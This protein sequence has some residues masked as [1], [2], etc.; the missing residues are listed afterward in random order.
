MRQNIEEVAAKIAFLFLIR[1][2]MPLAPL[3]EEFFKGHQG[4]YSIYIHADPSS[5]I[6]DNGVFRGRR[7]PSKV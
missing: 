1:E 3:W 6:V 5:L 2:S 4:F 7:I